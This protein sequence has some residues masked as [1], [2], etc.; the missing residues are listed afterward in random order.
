MPNTRKQ[1]PY[2]LDVLLAY[3]PSDLDTD[4]T[5]NLLCHYTALYHAT[6]AIRNQLLPCAARAPQ[7]FLQK[8][9]CK[10]CTLIISCRGRSNK[11]LVLISKSVPTL[12]VDKGQRA[13]AVRLWQVVFRAG[14]HAALWH[15]VD[16]LSPKAKPN[17]P[18][19]LPLAIL[20][21]TVVKPKR[22]WTVLLACK[23]LSY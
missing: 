10:T 17:A 6:A 2:Y 7:G 20:H 3:S 14:R 8:S 4:F 21:T 15:T 13:L 19:P 1:G 9:D 12:T 22:T 23:Y 16:W 18:R 5:N 11:E